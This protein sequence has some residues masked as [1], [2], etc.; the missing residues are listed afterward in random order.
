MTRDAPPDDV[1]HRRAHT[2]AAGE[3]Q[4]REVA[5]ADGLFTVRLPIA[6]TGEVRNEG[7]EPLTRDELGGMAEQI[8][9]RSPSVFLDHGRNMDIG[10]SRYSAI[11][12]VGEWVEPE[13]VDGDDGSTLLEVDARLMDPET[14]PAATGAVREALA[15]LKSQ[16]ERD[17]SLAASIGWQDDRDAPG[18]VDLM[19]ASLVGIPADPR[20]TSGA[21]ADAMTA[22]SADGGTER[23]RP[24]ATT[25]ALADPIGN[26][27]NANGGGRKP[28]AFYHDGRIVLV[29]GDDPDK[30][31]KRKRIRRPPGRSHRGR[32]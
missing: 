3:V 7:D 6:S 5:D 20:T 21:D 32:R 4:L 1:Q 25:R 29:E 13:L 31:D 30:K 17:L 9:A 2:P 22:R 10:G 27:R 23:S 28:F 11:G 16:V 24:S 15:A 12:K 26:G 19:E 18:G 14:L 8:E